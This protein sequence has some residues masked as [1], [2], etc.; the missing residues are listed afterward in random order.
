MTK[1]RRLDDVWLKAATLGCLWASA[2]I[3]LGSF[4]HNLRV[5]LAGYVMAGIGIVLVVSVSQL[6]PDRGLIWRAGLVCALMKA[7]APSAVILG[8][9]VAIACQAGLM[10]VSV[11]IFRRRTAGYLLGA[12]LAMSWNMIQVVSRTLMSYGQRV[13]DL[14]VAL[15]RWSEKTL[16]WAA[17]KTWT[18]L[19]LMLILSLVAGLAA[20]I[21]GVRIGRRAADEPLAMSSLSSAE[22]K[23][24]RYGRPAR[25]FPYSRGW[26]AA[27]IALLVGALVL[28][29]FAPWFVWLPAGM[30]VIGVWIL[31]YRDAARPLL[32]PGFWIAFVVLTSLS[33]ALLSSLKSGAGGLLGGI[34][35]GLTMNFR[36]AVMVAGFSALSTEL[37]SPRLG[38][39]LYRGRFRPL[40]AAI[41]AAVETL[42]MV[43]ANLP[44]AREV[45]RRP[46]AIFHRMV[47][48]SDYWLQRLTLR[49]CLRRG[50]LLLCGHV[51]AGK[52]ST[53]ERLVETL[54]AAGRRV[55]GIL[56]PA[57]VRDGE[58]VGYDLIDLSSGRRTELSRIA[59][60]PA[61]GGPFVGRFAFDLDG[62][63]AGRTA[64]SVDAASAADVVIVDEIG[65]WE[66]SDQGW[67]GPLYRLALDTETPMIWV[68]RSEIRDKVQSHWALRN[69]RVIDVSSVPADMLG[70]QV[71]E[72]LDRRKPRGGAAKNP[73]RS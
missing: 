36:A 24:I 46:A 65:P 25:A 32:R 73:S 5:P 53:L 62:L 71:L 66:L 55:A 2:E 12:M 20:G 26:F 10:D 67:A 23:N 9:M 49:Q 7:L 72:W 52:S 35:S 15:V 50:V 59:P 18:P 57:V 38:P 1:P 14:Y 64:L 30:L 17:G 68:V 21:L 69:P 40:P 31:R 8:P 34:A 29:G 22:V 37:R 33:G 19:L 27:D 6:W 43:M 13:V 48:Q 60:A 41:E 44:P 16:G 4:L 54:R 61:R 42:P 39:K 3:V 56:S 58:R 63:A 51:G 70:P 11:R 45:F 47:S 28:I